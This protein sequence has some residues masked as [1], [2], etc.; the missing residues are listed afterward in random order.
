MKCSQCPAEIP[1]DHG[2]N[3]L[4]L[5]CSM[6]LMTRV[7][8][9][10]EAGAPITRWCASCGAPFPLTDARVVRSVK[11]P[12]IGSQV[13]PWLCWVCA[14]LHYSARTPDAIQE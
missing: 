5:P 2:L 4:C 10:I 6:E 14:R 8:S 13:T 7:C 9:D 1:E 12:G 11:N 3:H